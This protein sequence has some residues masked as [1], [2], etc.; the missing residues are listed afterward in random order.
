MI[1]VKKGD[2]ISEYILEEPLGRG[3]FGE[4]WRARHHLWGDREVAVKIPTSPDAV[5]ELANEGHL[6]A[7]LDHPGIARTL[8]MDPAASPPYFITEY[9]PGRSLRRMLEVDGPLAPAAALDLLDQVLEA[10]AYAHRSGVVHQDI[11]P[12]NILVTD[13]GRA[14]L[15]DFGLGQNIKGESLLLS[16]SLRSQPLN[17]TGTLPYIA[18][19]IR[20]CGGGIDGRADLYS[21]GIVFFEMLT[22]KRPA[23]GEVPS[24]LAP[25]VPVTCDEIFRGLYTR[26]ENRFQD[27]AAVRSRVEAARRSEGIPRARVTPIHPPPKGI[28]YERARLLYGVSKRDFDAWI[29]NGLLESFLIDG[30]IHVSALDVLALQEEALGAAG[31]VSI[32]G[33]TVGRLGPLRPGGVFLRTLALVIDFWVVVLVAGAPSIGLPGIGWFV[34]GPTLPVVALLY[35]SLGHG[36]YGQTIGKCALGLK[37]VRRDGTTLKLADGFK[38]TL[39][40]ALSL[41]PAGLGFV[42]ALF[43]VREKLTFHDILCD[44]R[45]IRVDRSPPPRR[46]PETTRREAS[47]PS[48]RRPLEGKA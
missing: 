40:T 39:G 30:A 27:V 34:S 31:R 2:R 12:E 17:M 13:D 5:R 6:Q 18:P 10:L 21:L 29:A 22:G 3:G 45:V 8:G 14:K 11:K 19:E 36:L 48:D 15:T 42:L 28:T 7:Q 43:D 23:G 32:R 33:D 44:T 46:A 41:L 38:R 20:D 35:F 24:D 47:P 16:M 25:S 26:R 9:V 4:V 37:V 1:A